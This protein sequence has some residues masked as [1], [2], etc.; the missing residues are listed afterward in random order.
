MLYYINIH[1]TYNLHNRPWYFLHGRHLRRYRRSYN[2]PVL[3]RGDRT[4]RTTKSPKFP[5]IS[6]SLVNLL[7]IFVKFYKTAYAILSKSTSRSKFFY[8]IEQK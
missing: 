5:K 2:G 1:I 3:H 6:Q 4:D 7:L 8:G